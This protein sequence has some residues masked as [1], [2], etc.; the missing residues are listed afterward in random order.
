M[1]CYKNR[2]KQQRKINKIVRQVE[3][4]LNQDSLFSEVIN[5]YSITPRLQ[6]YIKEREKLTEIINIVA[7]P[8]NNKKL[9]KKIGLMVYANSNA[10]NLIRTYY[11]WL[12]QDTSW[13]ERAYQVTSEDEWEKMINESIIS[14]FN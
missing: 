12:K 5:I 8:K 3:K 2:K 6:F 1:A 11:E 7:S 13:I 10:D 9:T 14:R 4:V